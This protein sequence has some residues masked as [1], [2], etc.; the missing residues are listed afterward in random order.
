MMTQHLHQLTIKAP[1]RNLIQSLW[2]KSMMIETFVF[3]D[4]K[5]KTAKEVWKYTVFDFV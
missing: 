2:I 4:S 3:R 1:T 5:P